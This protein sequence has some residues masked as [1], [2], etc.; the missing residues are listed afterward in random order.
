MEINLRLRG[1]ASTDRTHSRRP[2]AALSIIL[3]GWHPSL[4]RIGD[5][6][7]SLLDIED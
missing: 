6:R 5:S 2:A 7:S 1:T 3:A 4:C